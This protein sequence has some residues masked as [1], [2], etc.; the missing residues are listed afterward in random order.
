LGA[1][2]KQVATLGAAT[3]CFLDRSR[4]LALVKIELAAGAGDGLEAVDVTHPA[5]LPAAPDGSPDGRPLP[6]MAFGYSLRGSFALDASR[7]DFRG[8][9]PARRLELVRAEGFRRGP[10]DAVP[11]QVLFRLLGDQATLEGMS[12]GLVVD[13]GGR[14]AGLVFGRRTDQFNVVI[15]A[16]AV[17]EVRAA[18]KTPG[19]PWSRLRDKGQ[20]EPRLFSGES[21]PDAPVEN[22][23]DWGSLEG[24]AV[25]LG[26]DPLRAIERFQEIIVTPPARRDPPNL[27][28]YVSP[29]ET[30]PNRAHRLHVWVNGV[31]K[32]PDQFT[33]KITL[34]LRDLPGE[35]MVTLFKESGRVLDFELGKLLLPSKVDLTFQYEGERPFL[36]VVRSLPAISQNY[37]LFVTVINESDAPPRAAAARP[38]ANARLALR[39]DYA[40]AI[41]NQAPFDLEVK[42]DPAENAAYHAVF[43]LDPD[44]AWDLRRL[45][46]QR[47]GL[48]LD[49]RL[50]FVQPTVRYH[51]VVLTPRNPSG[52]NDLPRFRVSGRF[53]FPYEMPGRDQAGGPAGL[54]VSPRATAT[55]GTGELRVP[56]RDGVEFDAAGLLRHLFTCEVNRRLI[57]DTRPHEIVYKKFVPFL[58]RLGVAAPKGW[59]A[60]MRRAVFARGAEPGKDWLILTFRLDPEGANVPQ[61]LHG[62]DP[63]PGHDLLAPPDGAKVLAVEAWGV[64][65]G[66]VSGLPGLVA[67]N[68]AVAAALASARVDHLALD[69]ELPAKPAQWF[70]DLA[71]LAPGKRLELLQNDAKDVAER[72]VQAL[73]CSV[74]KAGTVR[75]HARAGAAFVPD[76]VRAAANR[77]GLAA[78]RVQRPANL[79]LQARLERAGSRIDLTM[80][81]GPLELL[82]PAGQA[83]NLGGGRSVDGLCLKVTKLTVTGVPGGAGLK[84]EVEADLTFATLKA[85]GNTYTNGSG[86]VA[87]TL[88][89]APG[90]RGLGGG[91]VDGL[92]VTGPFIGG[93]AKYTVNGKVPLKVGRDWTVEFDPKDLKP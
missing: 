8:L 64:P 68:P 3:E 90:N 7:I 21:D 82:G 22:R 34:P 10:F 55:D 61:D 40:R 73:D 15:P 43:R 53:Q 14:F 89:T 59:V 63:P 12:G 11:D 19:R 23:L 80:S 4:E 58:E 35:T 37:P 20:F 72:V 85:G 1:E 79:T 31:S 74:R 78:L 62:G 18:S 30:F 9:V 50:V 57:G 75:L 60:D 47:L 6:G 44:A 66:V 83:I 56:V 38:P 2:S 71:P 42:N 92:Q 54:V 26:D 17:A 24:M 48:A 87:L 51:E 77:P 69:V 27:E 32:Q 16:E 76:L 13:A 81:A 70:P 5:D 29:S 84:A 67:N 28:I 33:Y 46:P 88:D 49:G 52:V 39:L 36:R 91:T 93:P 45:S 25:L 65:G 86:K 41:L